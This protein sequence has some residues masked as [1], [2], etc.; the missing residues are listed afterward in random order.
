MGGE[1]AKK[2]RKIERLIERKE[3]RKKK[4]QEKGG[5]GSKE[6]K[7]KRERERGRDERRHTTAPV[8]DQLIK[9]RSRMLL[10][11]QVVLR[12]LMFHR[13]NSLLFSCT[14]ATTSPSQSQ[15]TPVHAL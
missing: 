2:G 5:K 14:A 13:M 4:K 9:V 7:K 8:L 11:T 1:G 12:V 10:S 3:E 6:R 15:P